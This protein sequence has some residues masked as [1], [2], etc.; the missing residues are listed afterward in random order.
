MVITTRLKEGQGTCLLD[1][2]SN[3]SFKA[4]K[5]AQIVQTLLALTR[6]Q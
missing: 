1:L 2:A 4:F 3:M 6:P 5:Q